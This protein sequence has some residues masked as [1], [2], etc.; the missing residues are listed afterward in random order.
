MGRRTG[1]RFATLFFA[2][3]CVWCRWMKAVRREK[4]NRATQNGMH[5]GVAAK[6]RTRASMKRRNPASTD[7]RY[8]A[9]TGRWKTLDGRA[10]GRGRRAR[11]TVRAGAAARRR[12]TGHRNARQRTG[13]RFRGRN[14]SRL[15]ASANR[16]P[17]APEP[18]SRRV[19]RA[20]SQK[21]NLT[22]RAR[23]RAGREAPR[24]QAAEHPRSARPPV[25]ARRGARCVRYPRRKATAGTRTH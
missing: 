20:S 21:G 18:S 13:R 19:L 11:P 3:R 8:R 6:R 4:I 23:C 16:N 25:V 7:R 1:Q 9:L 14:A 17:F 5:P 12:R 15:P 22:V 10:G 2:A 24:A